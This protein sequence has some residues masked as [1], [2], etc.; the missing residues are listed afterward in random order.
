MEVQQLWCI[1]LVTQIMFEESWRSFDIYLREDQHHKHDQV[2][3]DGSN[4]E[5]H[6]DDKPCPDEE[7]NSLRQF[8]GWQACSRIGIGS[9]YAGARKVDESIGQLESSLMTKMLVFAF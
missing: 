5:D 7:C 6:G 1:T 4:S 2:A 3:S 9:K 8:G